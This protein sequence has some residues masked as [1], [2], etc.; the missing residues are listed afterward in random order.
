[1]SSVAVYGNSP[2]EILSES[3]LLNPISPYG[4]AKQSAELYCKFYANQYNL[5]IGIL[6]LFLP[7]V[8]A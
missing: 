8:Q 1:M 6:R 3:Q 5:K 7:M 4:L 2:T